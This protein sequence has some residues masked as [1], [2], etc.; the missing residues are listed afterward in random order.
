MLTKKLSDNNTGTVA[1]G[2]LVQ[3]VRDNGNGTFT[4]ILL[5]VAQIGTENKKIITVPA[6]GS[7]LTDTFFSNTITEIVTNNQAYIKDVDFTQSGTTITG[8][9]ITFVSGQVLIAKV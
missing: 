4:D 1:A 2:D 8:V 9:T 5:P 3:G 7:T 6:T